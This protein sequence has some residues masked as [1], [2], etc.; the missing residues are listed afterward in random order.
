MA[1]RPQYLKMA[2]NNIKTANLGVVRI[3]WISIIVSIIVLLL[4]TL[5]SNFKLCF[6]AA[7]LLIFF[8]IFNAHYTKLKDIYRLM[9]ADAAKDAE[10]VLD[11][12]AEIEKNKKSISFADVM[13][14]RT[15]TICLYLPMI[16][17]LFILG[18]V[19]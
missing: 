1:E 10:I 12:S 13:F 15:D 7:V 19:L 8:W 18:S 3:R 16:I 17:L 5:M 6:G 14:K 9:Y 11:F 2:I 4:A